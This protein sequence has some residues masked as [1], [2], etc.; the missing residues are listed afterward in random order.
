MQAPNWKRDPR[1]TPRATL[2]SKEVRM[3]VL[4]ATDAWHPQINGVLRTLESLQRAVAKLDGRIE[5]LT[6]DGFPSV[7]VPTYPQLRCALTS[8]REIAR[9]I[10]AVVADAIHIATEGTIG[11]AARRYCLSRGIS[12]TTSFTTRFAEYASAR[13]PIPLAWGYA[14]LRQF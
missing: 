8:R 6:P 10:E 3:R 7:P 1:C 5:F 12:F 13:F 2:S 9:R 14:V 11:L 4:V